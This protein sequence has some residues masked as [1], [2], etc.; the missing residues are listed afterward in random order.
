LAPPLSIHRNDSNY[1]FHSAA[2]SLTSVDKSELTP[3]PTPL[4][5]DYSKPSILKNNVNAEN[6]LV[7]RTHH[8]SMILTSCIELMAWM[9]SLQHDLFSH[10]H[11]HEN[12]T[13]ILIY[14]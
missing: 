10:A 14:E 11:E 7:V 1:S 8:V 13:L 3:P 5:A 9:T 12:W 4:K 2:A 6:H